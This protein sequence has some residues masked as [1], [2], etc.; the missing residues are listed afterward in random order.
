MGS[1]L[2]K[3]LSPHIT[4]IACTVYLLSLEN[5]ESSFA[6]SDWEVLDD[7]LSESWFSRLS[8]FKVTVRLCAEDIKTQG[9]ALQAFEE[10]VFVS[11]TLRNYL[12][13]LS[14][15]GVLKITIPERRGSSILSCYLTYCLKIRTCSA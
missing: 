1:A 2:S 11:S 14:E 9:V 15:S 4:E 8:A 7:V 13:Q 6:D 3:V 5:L 10:P 12:P